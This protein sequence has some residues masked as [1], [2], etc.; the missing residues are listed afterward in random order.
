MDYQDVSKWQ[1][2]LNYE[3]RVQKIRARHCF[4]QKGIKGITFLVNSKNV[5]W[6]GC[7]ALLLYANS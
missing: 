6:R 1:N 4:E 3:R 7:P 5:S 2:Y